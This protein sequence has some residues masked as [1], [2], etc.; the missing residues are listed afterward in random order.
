MS[1]FFSRSWLL[2]GARFVLF[3]LRLLTVIHRFESYSLSTAV[4]LCWGRVNNL[5]YTLNK[6]IQCQRPTPDILIETMG[7]E[8]SHLYFLKF[9]VRTVG[10]IRLPV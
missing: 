10:R 5:Y 6:K 2:C 3:V 8:P 7:M 4:D 1:K 9:K